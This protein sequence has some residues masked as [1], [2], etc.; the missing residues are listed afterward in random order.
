MSVVTSERAGVKVLKALGLT[1]EKNISLT[2]D[3]KPGTLLTATAVYAVESD[4]LDKTIEII[5]TLEQTG[6]EE[7]VL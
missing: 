3:F 6:L 5:K 2:L 7:K 1:V 4:G